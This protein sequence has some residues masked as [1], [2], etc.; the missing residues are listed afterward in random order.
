MAIEAKNF[1]T[2]PNTLPGIALLFANQGEAEWAVE[3]YALA[4]TQ[5]IVANS[6]W[7]DDIA[8]DHVTAIAASLPPDPYLVATTALMPDTLQSPHQ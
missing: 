2:L 7:F 3:L 6:R 4:S 1:L 8:G 5:C